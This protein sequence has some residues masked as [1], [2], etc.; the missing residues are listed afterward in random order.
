MRRWDSLVD[1]YIEEY[2]ARGIHPATIENVHRELQRWGNWMKRRR[3]RPQ[4]EAMEPDLLVRYLQHRTPFKSKATVYSVM[5]RM[6]GMGN[7]LVRQGVWIDNPLKWM[8]GPKVTAYHRMPKRI[9]AADMKVLWLAA[10]AAGQTLYRKHLG[11]TMLSLLYGTGLRRGELQRLRLKDWNREDGTLRI[12]GQKTGQERCVPVPS[13]VY[14]CVESYLPQR[15][16]HLEVCR[17]LDQQALLVNRHGNP[18]DEQAVSKLVHR[19]AKRAGIRLHSLHQFRHSCASDLIAAGVALPE[20]QRIL[21]HSSVATT[22]RY[23]HIADPERR[24]AMKR[25]P[26]NDW[27]AREAA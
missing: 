22:M 24:E 17:R 8:Q 10:A 20:V 16:N 19:I 4:L 23:L 13:I 2:V 18:L 6:R 21:G 1:T 3:P 27:L 7:F 26:L 14:H 11:I 5:S 25:H 12:D 15:H 9:G